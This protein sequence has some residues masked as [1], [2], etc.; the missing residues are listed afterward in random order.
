MTDLSSLTLRIPTTQLKSS[1]TQASPRRRQADLRTVG[2][3]C[4]NQISKD[5]WGKKKHA[6]SFVDHLK[7]SE[8]EAFALDVALRSYWEIHR[9]KDENAQ[10]SLSMQ[11]TYQLRQITLDVLRR[12]QLQLTT[13]YTFEIPDPKVVKERE[14]AKQKQIETSREQRKQ[15]AEAA[16][17]ERAER[18]ARV[19]ANRIARDKEKEKQN[20][21]KS[22]EK[23]DASDEK[24]KPKDDAPKSQKIVQNSKNIISSPIVISKPKSYNMASDNGVR[25]ISSGFSTE[26]KTFKIQPPPKQSSGGKNDSI[27][28]FAASKSM[29]KSFKITPPPKTNSTSSTKIITGGS[30]QI[31]SPEDKRAVAAAALLSGRANV[32]T[33]KKKEKTFTRPPPKILK[34]SKPDEE[35]DEELEDEP[36]PNITLKQTLVN[37]GE[38]VPLL[39]N[40]VNENFHNL[41]SSTADELPLDFYHYSV[42]GPRP[43]NE[44]EYTVIEHV[45]EL[46]GLDKGSD[47]YSFF[48]AYDGH[49]GKYTSLFIR[50]QIHHKVCRHSSFPDEMDTAIKESI[51]HID[52]LVND[53]QARDEFA[54]GSTALAVW[55]RNNE[56]LI[57]GNV[58]DCRGFISRGGVPI[59]IADPHNPTRPDEK[60]RIETLGGAVVKRGAWRVNGILAVSRSIGDHNLKKFVIA[61]PEVT[62]FKVLPEDEFI[63]IASDG[64]WDVLKPEDAIEIIHNTCKTKGRKFVCQTLCDEALDRESKDNVTVVVMFCNRPNEQEQAAT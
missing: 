37:T 27:A 33:S 58:G 23:E 10:C 4:H 24:D 35:D 5:L 6:N 20:E 17:K 12:H 55:V 7:P 15:R 62:R 48:A 2:I 18:A 30:I 21:K 53:V 11:S 9:A 50:S 25:K 60:S 49:C 14:A 40:A 56:E 3:Q 42:K 63:I 44:D 39:F 1:D 28:A 41:H 29:S 57:V 19:R 8:V 45:N 59:E 51:L 32:S 46:I 54:C 26:K 47:R 31:S 22:T 16:K 61:D 43:A 52:A 34:K 38:L 36:I 64:L 13:E